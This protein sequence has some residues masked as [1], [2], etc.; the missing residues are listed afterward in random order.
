MGKNQEIAKAAGIIGSATFL[1]RILGY[2]RD[3]IVANL[4][5]AGLATDAFIVASRIPNYLRRLFGE[6]TLNASLVPVFSEYLTRRSK[7]EAWELANVV[8]TSISA[9]VTLLTLLGIF[10]APWVVRGL[11]PG[12]SDN[13]EQF[14][15]AVLLTRV[16][17]PFAVFIGISAAVM[18]V[19]NSL[20]HFGAPALAPAILNIMMIL[21]AL[22]L[23]PH[24]SVP[25]L[26]LSIGILLGGIFQLLVQVPFL[27]KRGFRFRFRFQ[28]RH[29]GFQRVV[30]LMV[31]G[32][33]GQSVLQIN[34]FIGNILA[35]F[36]PTGSIS[37]LFFADRLVQFPLGVFGI[38]AATAMLPTL[39]Q[40]AA[41]KNLP[42]MV[43]TLGRTMRLV[44]FL[45]L[46]SL[47]GLSVLSV[48]IVSALFQR[49]NFS[50]SAT[51]ATA[52]ALLYYSLG[53][54]AFAEVRVVAQVYYALQDTWTPMK[55]GAT[56]VLANVVLSLVLMG[57]LKHGGLALANSL[58]SMLNVSLLV[59]ILRKRVGPLGGTAFL[60]LLLKILPASAILGFCAYYGAGTALWKLHGHTLE[61]FYRLGWGILLGGGGYTVMCLLFR[62]EEVRMVRDWLLRRSGSP[63]R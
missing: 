2:L 54:W 20:K 48:P 15:L 12:F 39:S 42:G 35:S 28:P 24:L 16:T 4:F 31:P 18:G 19:L 43:E 58:S 33:I 47:V 62:V 17:F 27:W 57:P 26:S 29:P 41:E 5:G 60:R 63:H 30:R 56:A 40:H 49:G 23:S 55:I 38:S 61:K 10:F 22:F 6:G 34:I 7:S 25:I 51:V 32:I 46:P 11:A 3:V 36:L 52:Q 14:A 37:F 13:P 44:I 53:L 50:Y 8:M 9:L 1:S 45:M 21:C 59:W